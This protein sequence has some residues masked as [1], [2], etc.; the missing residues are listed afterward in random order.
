MISY[1]A[2]NHTSIQLLVTGFKL[3]QTLENG[4]INVYFNGTTVN[5]DLWGTFNMTSGE[6]GTI[7]TISDEYAPRHKGAVYSRPYPSSSEKVFVNP[8]GQIQYYPNGSNRNIYTTLR[9]TI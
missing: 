1:S 4:K 6:V 8:Q 7:A 3:V 2:K 9:Y 5:I